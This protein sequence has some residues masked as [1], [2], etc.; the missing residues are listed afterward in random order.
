MHVH[1]L[2]LIALVLPMLLVASLA[3][4]HAAPLPPPP[5]LTGEV[6]TEPSTISVRDCLSGG[7]F[8]FSAAGPATGPYPGTFTESG[9]VTVDGNTQVTAFSATFTIQS[10][11]GTVT[12]QKTLDTTVPNTSAGCFNSTTNAGAII[13][14]TYTATI[15]TPTG[16][17]YHDQGTATTGVAIDGTLTV[18][19]EQFTSTLSQTVPLAPTSTDQCKHG[20][21]MNFIDPSTG[22]PFKN[23]GQCIAYVNAHS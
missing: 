23:Q 7:S 11:Q 15:V 6:L 21:Y 3:P 12:G 17:A 2:L 19:L 4:V 22:Q 20:G 9:S 14:T 18:L 16:S 8:T 5:T 1:R 13:P 10:P